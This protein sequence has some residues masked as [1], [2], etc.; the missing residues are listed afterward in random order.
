MKKYKDKTTIVIA[1]KGA[2]NYQEIEGKKYPF[3]DFEVVY[4]YARSLQ[5]PLKTD[6]SYP[7]R[8]EFK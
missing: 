1:G 5:K 3:S 7:F 6:K 2:E 8:D 4:N